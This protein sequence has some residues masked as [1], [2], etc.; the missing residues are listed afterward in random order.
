MQSKKKRTVTLKGFQKV[1]RNKLGFLWIKFSYDRVVT[2]CTE[3]TLNQLLIKNK[4]LNIDGEIEEILKNNASVD[5]TLGG[6]KITF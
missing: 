3:D 5:V 1:R 4:T 2:G 6:I